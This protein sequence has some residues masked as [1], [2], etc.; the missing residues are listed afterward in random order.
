[1]TAILLAIAAAAAWYVFFRKPSDGEAKRP[2]A[3]DLFRVPPQ[4]AQSPPEFPSLNERD[5]EDADPRPAIDRLL[6][7][8]RRLAATGRLDDAN[9]KAV[10]QLMLELV[11]GKAEAK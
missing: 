1:M 11:H 5:A 9:S 7:V 10:D 4:V 2:P 6:V 8:R 3:A